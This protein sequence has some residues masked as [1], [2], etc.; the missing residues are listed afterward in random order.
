MLFHYPG[1]SSQCSA[2]VQGEATSCLSVC[3]SVCTL[4]RPSHP[5]QSHPTTTTLLAACTPPPP[6]RQPLSPHDPSH[7]IPPA[8]TP[9]Q[10]P[11][12]RDSLLPSRRKR[13]KNHPP[14]PPPC[15]LSHPAP[16]RPSATSEAQSLA[17]PLFAPEGLIDVGLRGWGVACRQR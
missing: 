15:C 2:V 5:S 11:T 10:E 13:R 8:S 3:L 17:S 4:Y 1:Q 9:S 6:S 16:Q 7:L 12:H 14:H